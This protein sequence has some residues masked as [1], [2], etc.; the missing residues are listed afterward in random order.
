MDVLQS[1]RKHAYSVLLA[2]LFAELLFIGL[3]IIYYNLGFIKYLPQAVITVPLYTVVILIPFT[4]L[5]VSFDRQAVA[6]QTEWTPS[7]LYYLIGV[8]VIFNIVLLGQYIYTRRK[9]VQ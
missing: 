8:P 7:R 1:F 9:Y 6:E 4:V 3:V 2:Y 5:A